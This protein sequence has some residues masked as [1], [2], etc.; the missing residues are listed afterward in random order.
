MRHLSHS[1]AIRCTRVVY[2]AQWPS[3]LRRRSSAARLL[4]LWV[5]K[6]KSH[7]RHGCLS[8]CLLWVLCIVR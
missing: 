6:K 8:V 3:G 4:M 7:R 1:A 5:R 2:P